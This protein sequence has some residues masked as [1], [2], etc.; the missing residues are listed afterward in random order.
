MGDINANLIPDHLN[1]DGDLFAF[2]DVN[3][4]LNSNA[5]VDGAIFEKM[6][7][8]TSV[9]GEVSA[10]TTANVTT[11]LLDKISARLDGSL[12]EKINATF[13]VSAS[14]KELAP[15]L[16]TLLWTEIP[17]VKLR[18]PHDYTLGVSFC[19][20]ELFAFNFRG[21]TKAVSAKNPHGAAGGTDV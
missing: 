8:H 13:G 3:A 16:L 2:N 15:L 12:L 9:G 5:R 17:I 11:D 14:V 1:V 21:E 6:N 7:L 4:T 19:G 20:F 18:I 10:H